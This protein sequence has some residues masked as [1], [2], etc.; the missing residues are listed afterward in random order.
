MCRVALRS[1]CA[2]CLPTLQQATFAF[3]RIKQPYDVATEY[4][5]VHISVPRQP[6]K[7]LTDFHKKSYEQPP[8]I[9]ST[10]YLLMSVKPLE[11]IPTLS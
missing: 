1:H 3:T 5:P 2:H 6:L 11:G 9:V 8:N 4:V 7:Y 10:Y